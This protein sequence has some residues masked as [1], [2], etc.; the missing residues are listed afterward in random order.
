MSSA[1]TILRQFGI[2]PKRHRGQNFLDDAN[3]L[4][5]I[6]TAAH[7]SQTETVV[8]V[9]PGLGVLTRMLAGKAQR[10]IAVELDKQL[11]AI[12][13]HGFLD[14]PS[15]EII[16]DDILDVPSS[17]FGLLDGSYRVIANIPY[18][19][20]SRLI[21]KFLEEHPAP[22][23][24]I[25]LIQKEVAER[26][27][28]GPG[29]HSILSLSVQVLAD[30]QYLFPVSRRCF[31]PKPNVDSAVIQITPRAVSV[32]DACGG[33]EWF[34][35]LLHAGFAAKRKYLLSNL[36]RGLTIPR[37]SVSTVFAT[38]SL[39]EKIRAQDLTVTEWCDLARELKKT[40]KK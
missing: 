16:Q 7:I 5:K 12:L 14:I 40:L 29:E 2:E 13:A 22:S 38:L 15:V 21:R 6:V 11:A 3:I 36:F 25:L 18:N 35:K 10:L 26:M 20:T 39:D 24:L 23:S 1:R 33:S 37:E 28:S 32:I 8:E 17:R 30:V 4:T 31:Y 27:L 19:I 34:F 9:G